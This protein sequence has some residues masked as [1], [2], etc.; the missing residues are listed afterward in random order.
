M[1]KNR[2]LWDTYRFPS[3]RP[4]PII[5]GIFGDPKARVIRLIRKGKKQFV[6]PAGRFM[7]PF[8]TERPAEFET[9]LAAIPAS[10]WRWKS[11]GWIA[12]RAGK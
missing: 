11:V 5:A 12:G 6:E 8:T 9:S 4:E 10:T 3:F 2:K 7:R 1:A